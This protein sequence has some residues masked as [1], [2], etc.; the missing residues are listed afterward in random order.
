MKTVATLM[1]L[2]AG[3]ALAACDSPTAFDDSVTPPSFARATTFTDNVS[4]PV[5]IGVFIPCAAGGAGE[6]VFLS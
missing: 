1:T 6:T 2:A 3:F 4:F 5:N